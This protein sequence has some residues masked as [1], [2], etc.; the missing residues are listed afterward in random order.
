MKEQLKLTKLKFHMKILECF[1]RKTEMLITNDKCT[2][3]EKQ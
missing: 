2:M 3:N 1:K